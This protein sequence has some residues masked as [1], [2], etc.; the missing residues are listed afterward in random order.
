MVSHLEFHSSYLQLHTPKMLGNEPNLDGQ[1]LK[2]S[3]NTLE[4]FE[5]PVEAPSE[6]VVE[7]S[8]LPT[9]E[10]GA[11][12]LK[13]RALALGKRQKDISEPPEA[14]DAENGTLM[15]QQ[16]TA[17]VTT[18]KRRRFIASDD[19]DEESDMKVKSFIQEQ[20]PIQ[21]LTESVEEHSS[22]SNTSMPSLSLKN[23]IH[24]MAPSAATQEEKE[25]SIFD[26]PDELDGILDM[27]AAFAQMKTKIV[28]DPLAGE[29]DSPEG[30][31][32]SAPELTMTAAQPMEEEEELLYDSDGNVMNGPED[33]SSEEEPEAEPNLLATD[34]NK[35]SFFKLIWS[36]LY[37]HTIRTQKLTKKELI[38]LR[39]QNARLIRGI[40]FDF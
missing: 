26:N 23:T 19:E 21:S 13:G 29:F 34:P 33:Y 35:V 11:V 36:D 9:F 4:V 18:T 32:E 12:K 30:M 3:T 15:P 31:S 38:E 27:N 1:V 22:N 7:D 25:V 20:L 39:K 5:S 6:P 40:G 24:E 16:E 2:E 37:A 28:K 14:V 17:S 8:P 10:T